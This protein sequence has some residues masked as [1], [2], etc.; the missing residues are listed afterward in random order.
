M[1]ARALPDLARCQSAL[2]IKP[3]SLG[4]IIHTLP[5]VHCLKRGFPHLRLRWLCNAEWTLLLEGNP[6]IAE[7]VP[8][9]RG[10]FRGAG[11]LGVLPWA[12]KLNRAP[13]ELPEVALDF[14]GLLRSGLLGFARGANPVIGLSDAREGASFFY[15]QKI[16]VDA[17]AHAVDRY[18]E[19]PRALGAAVDEVA[20]PL[21]EGVEPKLEQALPRE[22]IVV[23]PYARGE[24]KSLDDKTLQVLCDC[25]APQPV[26]LVGK[27][28]G[29]TKINGS[30]VISLINR[31]SLTE[32]LW[33][34]RRARFIVSVDSGPMHLAAALR[35]ERALGIYTW[36]DPRQVGPYDKRAWIWKAGRVAHRGDFTEEE[37]KANAPF[38]PSDARS[39]ANLVLQS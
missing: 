29:E 35:P 16:P 33:L 10:K 20:F 11:L 4:D 27:T 37:A 39:I 12:W 34:L 17:A 26:L 13:R 23:H 19:L 30:H 22:F 18:L 9:P 32:L 25:L 3:S 28:S 21:P 5:A 36:S 8:F 14:Q 24:G 38:G 6:D 31:T 7:V 1:S 15:H 2:I